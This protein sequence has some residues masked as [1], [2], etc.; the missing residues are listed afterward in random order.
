MDLRSDKP[1]ALLRHGLMQVYPSLQQDI[2][3][4][5]AIIGA[6]ITGSLIGWHLAKSGIPVTVVDRRHVAMGSTAA[7]T[8]LLQY[9]IDTPLQK[10]MKLVGEK[11]AVL[12]YL[13]CRQ[14]IY[15]IKDLSLQLNTPTGF[16]LRPSLQYASFKRDAHKLELEC[17]LRKK[18][19]INVE[20][21]DNES[22]RG[23]FG[24]DKPAGMLSADGAVMDPYQFT[25]ALLKDASTKGLQVYDNTR[26]EHI[27]HEKDKVIL[28]TEWDHTITAKQLI[29]ACGYESQ[30]HLPHRVEQLRSTYS[31]IS[32]P[33]TEGQLWYKNAMIWE[34]ADPYLYLRTTEDH[35]I[36]IGGKDDPF[37]NPARRDANIPR[38]ST[39][40]E[41]SFRR[42]FPH[43]P[44]RTDFAWAGTFAGT[45][46]GLPYIGAIPARPHTWFALGYGG[47]GIIF[48]MIAARI[49]NDLMTGKNN[50]YAA[51][52]SFD[53]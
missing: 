24:F 10:L 50:P 25:H 16:A 4:D 49:L 19:G 23:K 12:S 34:T 40:L 42:L 27:S 26:V 39:L 14:A 5:V 6:G 32:E 17:Q 48:S 38:K 41:N 46:D 7:S 52:F 8:A 22:L 1:F 31:I 11:N 3:T 36:I 44:F 28:K 21:L 18:I 2:S 15:D 35:R 9:E 33:L 29:I 51:I 43:I 37:S 45:K 30:E 53:R 20:W 13:L 47:N